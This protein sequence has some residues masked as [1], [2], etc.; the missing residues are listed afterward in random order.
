MEPGKTS[1]DAHEHALVD[2]AWQQTR[3]VARGPLPQ[4]S[5]AALEQY[6]L[7]SE[8]HR[9]GQAVVYQA[10]Q[11]STGRRVAIKVF[12]GGLCSDANMTPRFEREVRILGALKHPN[13]VTVHDSG[14][15]E[16]QAYVV[17]DLI[18]GIPLDQWLTESMA[19]RMLDAGSRSSLPDGLDTARLFARVC[20]AVNEAH[21]RGIIHRDLK[22]NNILVDP[23]G[24][25]HILDFGLAKVMDSEAISPEE[26]MTA[27]GQFIGSAPW[28]S[29]EQA[30][31]QADTIDM[32]T[33]VYSLGVMLY[34]ALTGAF[35]YPVHGNLRDILRSIGEITPPVPRSVNSALDDEIETIVLRCLAKEPPRRYE[36]AGELGRDLERY[37]AGEP[38]EAKRDSVMYIMRKR[39]RR[40]RLTV[41]IGLCFAAVISVGL[42]ASLVYSGRATRNAALAHREAAT[43]RQVIDFLTEDL[44]SAADPWAKAGLGR[45]VTVETL[46]D[47]ASERLVRDLTAQ[48]AAEATIRHTI[49][50][51]YTRLARYDEAAQHLSQALSIR[52]TALGHQDP[53]TLATASALGNVY[54]RQ[55]RFDDAEALLSSTLND[56]ALAL[57]AHHIDTL[58]TM[59]ALARTL[60]KGKDLE[61]AEFLF[62]VVIRE[63][64]ATLGA[65]DLDT[66]KS[67][68]AL[69]VF[70]WNNSR[71]DEASQTFRHVVDMTT[72]ELPD[73]HP[74]T[75]T[76]LHNMATV[77]NNLGQREAAEP[78]FK[79][80]LEGRR[81]LGD[82]PYLAST[83]NNLAVLYHYSGDFRNARDLNAE[84]LKVYRTVY[85]ASHPELA[86]ALYNLGEAH[87][88]LGEYA[89]AE[90]R[91]TEALEQR[92]EL[93]GDDHGA[94]AYSMH[95]LGVV[96]RQVGRTDDAADL[97]GQALDFRLEALGREHLLTGVTV[98]ELSRLAY[99]LGELARAEQLS[100]DGLDIL[101]NSEEVGYDEVYYYA[102]AA[103]HRALALS[104]LNRGEV[105]QAETHLRTAIELQLRFSS[106]KHLFTLRYNSEL[107]MVLTAAGRALEARNLCTGTL[108]QQR[109]LVGKV[110][111]DVAYSL[112]VNAMLDRIAGDLQAARRSAAECLGIRQ[113]LLPSGHRAVADSIVLLADIDLAAG[114]AAEVV[115]PQLEAAVSILDDTLRQDWMVALAMRLTG[116]CHEL[117]GQPEEALQFHERADQIMSAVHFAPPHIR[118]RFVPK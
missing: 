16:G 77:L 36:T 104:L 56:Q 69:G 48:P 110:H 17:M 73:G 118:E 8:I 49:G 84:G 58:A 78:L 64:T 97:L 42:A 88:Y 53:A 57:G 13:I 33:D 39:I 116:D 83:M 27:T 22:P 6:E 34:K 4:L 72:S 46:L 93:Y 61:R 99:T 45:Q 10:L 41:A 71:S 92:R 89:A 87:R 75:D 81:A 96:A 103:A 95:A 30:E 90:A 38:I 105:D 2:N 25:P 109:S 23:K 47:A 76:A 59:L 85:R 26:T 80:A 79:Q 21:L 11:R 43:A 114:T 3:A 115:A 70:L 44:L 18:Q 9:G 51:M 111:P 101:L 94:V 40:H 19:G 50:V 65:A 55:R 54:Y 67:R 60:G 113:Q 107:A 74:M 68:N 24:E 100:R 91:H 35:P 29:P 117:Q 12:H 98:I 86:N 82:H 62:R 28:A 14:L 1:E 112:M 37:V 102:I 52:K 31:G 20:R 63:R 5:P 32:R 7:V 66:I 108:Q 106:D 15:N